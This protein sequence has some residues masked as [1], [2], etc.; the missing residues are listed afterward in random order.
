MKRLSLCLTAGIVMWLWGCPPSAPAGPEPSK[1]QPQR[2][3]PETN[4]PQANVPDSAPLLLDDGPLLLLDDAQAK[5]LA[6]TPLVDNSRCHVCHMNYAMEQLAVMHAATNIGCIKCHGASDAHIADES[7]ASGGNGTA[8]DIMFPKV[9]INPAC[10]ECHEPRKLSPKDHVDFLWG[11][12]EQQYCT[13]CH[14]KQHRL[15]QR[16]CKWK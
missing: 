1:P 9:K 12:A 7:W 6:R 4:A 3:Q 11:V 8:P 5:F 10:F 2:A 13:D 15:A 16:K 14:G